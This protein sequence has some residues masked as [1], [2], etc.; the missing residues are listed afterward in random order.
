MGAPYLCKSTNTVPNAGAKVLLFSE[1][2]KKKRK[3][4]PFR[5]FLGGK[6]LHNP[7]FLRNFAVEI[8]SAYAID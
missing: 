4:R 5:P 2:C 6:V 8:E 3:N 1:I 7:I